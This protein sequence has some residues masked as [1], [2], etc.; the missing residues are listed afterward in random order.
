MLSEKILDNAMELFADKNGSEWFAYVDYEM[1]ASKEIK[2]DILKGP[3]HIPRMLMALISLEET[4][5]ILK[6]MS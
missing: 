2:G 1:Y 5:S 4:G 6:Y 3:F